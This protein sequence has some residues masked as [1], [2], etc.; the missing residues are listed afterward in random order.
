MSGSLAAY[1]QMAAGDAKSDMSCRR[2]NSE[3]LKRF[4]EAKNS[5]G[6][7]YNELETYVTDLSLFYDEILNNNGNVPDEQIQ[8]IFCFKESIK[9]IRDMFMRDTMKVVFFGR[10]SNGKSSIINAMLHAKVL[11]QGMGHTTCCFLQA[12]LFVEGSPDGEQFVLNENSSERISIEHLQRLGHAMSDNNVSLTAMGQDSLLRVFYPKSCSRLL[13]ND[14]VIVDSPGVDLSPEFDS[15]IDK[16]CMDADVFVLVCNA[17]STLTQAEKS[18]FH[19]VSSKLS[20]PNV[21]ILNN[22]WDASAVEVENMQQ[23]REQHMTRFKQFLV[24]ELRVCNESEAGNRIFFVSAREM[25]DARL[26]ERGIIHFAYQVDGHQ[27]RAMEFANFE[28]QFEQLI[29]KSAISTKF[30]AHERRAREIVGAMRNNLDLVQNNA[31]ERKKEL[32]NSY[33]AKDTTF[34][35]CLNN[36]K[37]FERVASIESQ[38]L[39]NE[40]HLKVSADFYEELQR[41]ESII[42]RFDS[43][44]VDEPVCINQYKKNLADFVGKLITE[45]LE[46]RCTRGL[47]QRIW[48][49]E[50]SMYQNVSQILVEPYSKKL[51]QIW[52]YRAPF[53][54][55]ICINCPSL[56]EDFRE[57]L[58]FRFSF[59][60]TSLIRRINA[61][62]LG[63]PITAIGSPWSLDV[64]KN[65]NSQANAEV[66]EASIQPKNHEEPQ[67]MTSADPQE[68]AIVTQLA[69]SSVSY[70]ANGGLGLLVI[71][72]IVSK[73]VSWRT[74][75]AGIILYSGLYALEYWR[76]NS[77]AKEQHFKDQFRHHLSARMRGVA[78]THTLH[79]ET[80]VLR[81]MKQVISGL[82][83][84]VGSVHQEMMRELDD[85]RREIRRIDHITK[86]L[87]TIKGKTSFLNTDLDRFESEF[88]KKG[89][90]S[91]VDKS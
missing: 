69:L 16:H 87:N 67:L 73:T 64:F 40:V 8:E 79:C 76:W 86:G 9:T 13:Q 62:R 47:I 63:K 58:E 52:R 29:S 43:K 77:G 71:G 90:H 51:E 6:D 57:D 27:Y 25:L 5:I 11:P 34:K 7:I 83:S 10:T 44:F 21:F 81:E 36:W 30:E 85:I 78:A 56:M 70:V 15:W 14:V 4:T 65:Y 49:L 82:K 32:Q 72:G 37:E 80:Q 22:R 12:S 59:G 50:N 54:F 45:D 55:S 39:R 75:A 89:S 28:T 3:P 1:H 20:K 33:A 84:T 23:I 53:N 68:N 24:N 19:R 60:L 46:A 18:F 41:L 2:F 35:E 38:R 42:D 91:P 61:Y 17:E 48:N 88:L 66:D 31:L 26:K 74:I